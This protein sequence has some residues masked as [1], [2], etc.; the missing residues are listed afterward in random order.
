M[1]VITVIII[2]VAAVAVAVAIATNPS[3]AMCYQ[4]LS[5]FHSFGG[6]LATFY[7]NQ[8]DHSLTNIQR[9]SDWELFDYLLRKRQPGEQHGQRMIPDFQ[10]MR[11][12][13]R[14]FHRSVSKGNEGG[15]QFEL[16]DFTASKS[17][18]SHTRA[19]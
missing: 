12:V 13:V 4:R 19:V 17:C 9:H 18:R 1:I 14:H 8:L 16:V 2:V 3:Q 7:K 10:F 5:H 6:D 11:L 15:I